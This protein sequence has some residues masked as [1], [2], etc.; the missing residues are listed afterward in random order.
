MQNRA[1][2]RK[3]QTATSG[4]DF[5]DEQEQVPAAAAAVRHGCAQQ[6]IASKQA[7]VQFRV[8][9]KKCKGRER[10]LFKKVVCNAGGV[11]H[12]AMLHYSQ[13]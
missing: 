6:H 10:F 2:Y 12:V 3:Q 5:G 9:A 4:E 8:N 1:K 11:R 13:T 7:P